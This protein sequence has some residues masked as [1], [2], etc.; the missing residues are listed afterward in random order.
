[1]ITPEIQAKII[2]YRQKANEG[3]LSLDEMK[4]AI[5]MLRGSRRSA[6][7]SSEQ[8]KRVKAKKEVKSADQLL[9]ELGRL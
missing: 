5:L 6:A 9:D 2:L 3:T 4:E 1:M 8:A 7:V